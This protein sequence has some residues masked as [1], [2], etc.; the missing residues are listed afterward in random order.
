MTS[1]GYPVE[2]FFWIVRQGRGKSL[3]MKWIT[4]Q[5][6]E[7]KIEGGNWTV[8]HKFN[9]SRII[10]YLRDREKEEGGFSFVPD[11]YADI[12]DTYYAASTLR[13]W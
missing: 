5:D 4:E 9:V 11:L 12:E 8:I 3:E 1:T 13:S 10:R 7:P 6:S 2:V